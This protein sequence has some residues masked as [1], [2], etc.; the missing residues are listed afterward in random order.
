MFQYLHSGG[1]CQRSVEREQP[2]DSSQVHKNFHKFSQNTLAFCDYSQIKNFLQI[3]LSGAGSRSR[4]KPPTIRTT[5]EV[6]LRKCFYH[7][8][9]LGEVNKHLDKASPFFLFSLNKIRGK[10]RKSRCHK[11]SNKVF[12]SW[13]PHQLENWGLDEKP[14][15]PLRGPRVENCRYR[16]DRRSCKICASCV[17]FSRKQRDFSHNLRRTS[18]FTH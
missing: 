7:S 18:R 1:C 15:G 10:N 8:A 13:W 5:I 11:G 16:H 17:N 9:L 4:G 6:I 2:L 12:S 3:P 14:Q